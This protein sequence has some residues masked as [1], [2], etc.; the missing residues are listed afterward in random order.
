MIRFLAYVLLLTSSLRGQN[1]LF[2]EADIIQTLAEYRSK[3]I[4]E[5]VKATDDVR[6]LEKS[7]GEL[8]PDNEEFEILA[9]NI[10]SLKNKYNYSNQAILRIAKKSCPNCK[11]VDKITEQ[12][13]GIIIEN[14]ELID[15]VL[16]GVLKSNYPF[17]INPN[18]TISTEMCFYQIESGQK[19]GEIG[20]GNGAFSI[21][22]GMVTK[23]V[24]IYI[25]ELDKGFV[26]YIGAKINKNDQLLDVSKI[27]AIQGSK[28]TTEFAENEF[29]R[30]IIRNA[31]HHFTKKEKMLESIKQALKDNGKLCLYEPV[32]NQLGGGSNCEKV[33]DRQYLLKIIEESGFLLEEE[34]NLGNSSILLRFSKR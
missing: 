31:F 19:I 22:L 23:E 1:S 16:D 5:N 34:K 12:G 13:I 14:S 32:L 20:A 30:I 10:I 26:D 11:L 24:Q 6:M 27:E 21:I 8:D 28:S 15:L 2:N 18:S 17:A 4:K 25:N 9:L 3:L 33:L 29:D 7:W